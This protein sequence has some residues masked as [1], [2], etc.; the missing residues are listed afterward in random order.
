VGNFHPQKF[1]SSDAAIPA[2]SFSAPTKVNLLGMNFF[3]FATAASPP[4]L[5]YDH[6]LE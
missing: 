5:G 4:N 2:A 3:S 1:G 6:H